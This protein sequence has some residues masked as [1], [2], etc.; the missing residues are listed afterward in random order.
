[1]TTRRQF[2]ISVPAAAAAFALTDNFTL[3]TTPARAQQIDPLA[4]HF[5]P[6]GKAPS[7][8]TLEVLEA[9]LTRYPELPRSPS[10]LHEKFRDPDQVDSGGFF[11]RVEGEIRFKQGKYRGQPLESIALR[12]PGYLR[13]MLDRDFYDDTKAIAAGALARVTQAGECV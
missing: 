5:H 10:E 13:W 3:E 7:K 4:G 9:M 1:M 11:S 12:D 2:M 8:F 6:M